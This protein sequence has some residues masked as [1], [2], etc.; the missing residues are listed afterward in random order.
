MVDDNFV[1]VGPG[2][3]VFAPR[4]VKHTWRCISPEGGNALLFITPG[5]NFEHFALEMS[6]HDIF[7]VR[8]E[9][10]PTLIQLCEEHGLAILPPAN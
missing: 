5:A 8:P 2:D 1:E 3:T 6:K 7:P 10:I 9:T 4:Y